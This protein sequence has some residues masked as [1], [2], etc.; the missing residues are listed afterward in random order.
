MLQQRGVKKPG[1]T[2]VERFLPLMFAY[3]LPASAEADPRRESWIPPSLF[4]SPDVR[5]TEQETADL[6]EFSRENRLSV[7][8]VVAAAI[9]LTEWRLRD[10]PHVPIPY[11]YPVDLRYFLSPPV[12][13][14]ES[15]NL[16]GLATYLAEIGPDTDIVDLATDIGETFR[17]DLADGLIH[18]SALKFRHG[19]STELLPGCR[20]LS[21]P[22]MSVRSH[23]YAHPK[24]PSW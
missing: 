15:T 13:A 3:E 2:G 5:L 21:W 8:T 22:R 7:N 1:L 23:P 19:S 17:A 9:L 4:R 24:T 16:V 18:Q 10:T 6:V 11:V 14:T 12:G 20:H